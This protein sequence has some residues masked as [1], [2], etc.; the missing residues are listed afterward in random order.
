MY[1]LVS[2]C[3]I[4]SE[5]SECIP[6]RVISST[7]SVL[8]LESDG[9]WWPD[10]FLLTKENN[11]F[12]SHHVNNRALFN[13]TNRIHV[14]TR[15]IFRRFQRAR[16]FIYA[17]PGLQSLQNFFIAESWSY[18]LVAYLYIGYVFVP[19]KSNTIVSFL[20]TFI[21]FS[22]MCCRFA[23]VYMTALDLHRF[24]ERN[25]IW[26]HVKKYMVLLVSLCNV[27][28]IISNENPI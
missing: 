26:N 8:E 2:D 24:T 5:I 28:C 17:T 25:W 20:M 9:C 7:L 3:L 6:I 15:W 23:Q 12:H 4:L 11:P 18:D 16:I 14:A 22:R 21:R 10:S 13:L 19:K 27:I 1:L